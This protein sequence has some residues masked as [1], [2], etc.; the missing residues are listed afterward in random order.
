VD[1]IPG[2]EVTGV[3]IL[4]GSGNSAFDRSVVAAI[5]KASPLPQPRDPTVFARVIKITFIP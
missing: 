5:N 1:Q 4:K 3:K 2:G